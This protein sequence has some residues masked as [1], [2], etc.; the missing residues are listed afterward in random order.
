MSLIFVISLLSHTLSII[1][2]VLCN[3][4]VF[5]D[6]ACRNCLVSAERVVK[7]SDFGMT[8]PMYESDYYRFNRRGEEEEE[9]EW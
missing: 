9:E 4:Y 3:C 2:T 5:R 6:V 7:L 1:V 8:R